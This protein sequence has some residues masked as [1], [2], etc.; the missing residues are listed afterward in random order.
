MILFALRELKVDFTALNIF[1]SLL[2]EEIDDNFLFFPF[3]LLSKV[4]TAYSSIKV[5]DDYCGA[6]KIGKLL[7]PIHYMYDEKVP[8]NSLTSFKLRF[9]PKPFLMDL[10]YTDGVTY[11]YNNSE[12]TVKSNTINFKKKEGHLF[13]YFAYNVGVGTYN[14]TYSLKSNIP[15]SNFIQI[16]HNPQRYKNHI[17]IS[18]P[19]IVYFIFDKYIQELDL[20]FTNIQFIPVLKKIGLNLNYN[21]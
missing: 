20:Y 15:I 11:S 21:I 2:K 19:S 9:F 13:S 8:V 17:F 12:L 10:F 14:I 18:A 4:M 7:E 16:N 5:K 3:S 1:S 6:H